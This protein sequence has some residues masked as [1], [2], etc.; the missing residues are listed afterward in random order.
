MILMLYKPEIALTDKKRRNSSNNEQLC[1]HTKFRYSE[2]VLYFGFPLLQ[3]L[4]QRQTFVNNFLGSL[5]RLV[6]SHSRRNLSV[7]GRATVAN[8]LLLSTCWNIFPKVSWKIITTPKSCGGLGILDPTTQQLALFYR[9]VD[10]L[11]FDRPSKTLIQQFLSI[12]ISNCFGSNNVLM[13]LLFPKARRSL[14]GSPVSI[15]TLACRVVDVIPRKSYTYIPA[16]LDV[17]LLPLCAI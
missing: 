9:W 11:L 14:A 8:S 4:L 2:V 10:G 1:I 16:T 3:S 12:H 15:S 7:L 17:L 13:C 6:D 5:Q